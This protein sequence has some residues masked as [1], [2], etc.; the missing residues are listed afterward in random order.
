MFINFVFSLIFIYL[1][2]YIG[3]LISFLD[4]NDRI[5]NFRDLF[6]KMSKCPHCQEK[7]KKIDNIPI[8]SFILQKNLCLYCNEK[9]PLEQLLLEIISANLFG[10]SYFVYGFS[11]KYIFAIL[12]I[13]SVLAISYIDIKYMVVPIYL[14][15]YLCF[16][17]I[18]FILF[19]P[20]DPLFSILC[21]ILY[22]FIIN[23]SAIILKK[24][25]NKEVIG[26]ADKILFL[27]C[28]L[29]LRL[30]NLPNYL[31]ISGVNGITT[32]YLFKKF[33]KDNTDKFPFAPAILISLLICLII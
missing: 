11:L 19:N 25:K 23:L 5:P 26:G 8:V 20:I 31:I 29:I 22:Y 21:A 6:T 2:A 10:I 4:K 13:T 1:G 30:E 32:F 12:I 18:I 27:I 28:G 9:L 14:Q 7:F 15:V 17:A 3:G 16:C 33:I 24:F